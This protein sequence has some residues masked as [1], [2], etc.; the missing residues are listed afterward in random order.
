MWPNIFGQIIL[1]MIT[2]SATSHS[3][4]SAHPKKF[5]TSVVHPCK[6]KEQIFPTSFHPS[7]TKEQ[8]PNQYSSIQ[9]PEQFFSTGALLG[10]GVALWP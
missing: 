7:K 6:T 1:W 2:T 3:P 5:P 9:N 8:V 10:A 4:T